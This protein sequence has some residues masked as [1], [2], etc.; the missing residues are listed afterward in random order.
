[1][2]KKDEKKPIET[3]NTTRVIFGVKQPETSL[4]AQNTIRKGNR[5]YDHERPMPDVRTSIHHGLNKD[6][7]TETSK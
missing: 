5:T 3:V 2:S 6:E 7:P 1:M 4:F